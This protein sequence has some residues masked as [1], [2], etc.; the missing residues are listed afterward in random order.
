MFVRA[1][2]C[3]CVFIGLLVEASRD[4][5]PSDRHRDVSPEQQHCCFSTPASHL[6]KNTHT[7]TLSTSFFQ[8]LSQ[9]LESLTCDKYWFEPT[10]WDQQRGLRQLFRLSVVQISQHWIPV[11]TSQLSRTT[12]YL[13]FYRAGGHGSWGR[14]W[15]PGIHTHNQAP[16]LTL[17]SPDSVGK[18]D[19]K[20][21]CRNPRWTTSSD[22]SHLSTW[23]ST[24][25]PSRMM[26]LDKT[27]RTSVAAAHQVKHNH[28]NTGV[29]ER[30][31]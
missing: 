18:T 29:S 23:E 13:H 31:R 24:V 15:T 10:P 11:S 3:V 12:G 20:Q 22:N 5:F 21:H 1:C 26:S 7:H 16:P 8:L 27:R 19:N 4:Q 6:K 2:V 14:R 28:F 9:F 30:H 17:R 25:E